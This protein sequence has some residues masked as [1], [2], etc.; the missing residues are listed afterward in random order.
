LREKQATFS[1]LPFCVLPGIQNENQRRMDFVSE[2]NWN[3]L[4]N[5]VDRHEEAVIEALK[6]NGLLNAEIRELKEVIV[7]LIDAVED[8]AQAKRDIPAQE[9]ALYRFQSTMAGLKERFQD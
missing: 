6:Q 8:L 7:E 2:E 3:N 5:D 1:V 9:A 4:R